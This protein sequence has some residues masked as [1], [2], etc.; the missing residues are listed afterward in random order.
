MPDEDPWM[1]RIEDEDVAPD[2][3]RGDGGLGEA[4]EKAVTRY[5]VWQNQ[6]SDP[7]TGSYDGGEVEFVT[8]MFEAMLEA[9]DLPARLAAVEQRAARYYADH[10]YVEE[11]EADKRAAERQVEALR[12]DNERLSEAVSEHPEK[13]SFDTM[14]FIA[15]RVLDVWYPTD[16]K[17]VCDK[18]APDPGP[19]LAA[20]L[21]DCLAA[22]AQQGETP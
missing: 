13:W 2:R 12:E 18:D 5:F 9:S 10:L 22:L 16:V 4:V 14:L 6:W 1:S 17:V 19:R 21:H 11:A 20:A 15:R 3:I 7:E 8:E